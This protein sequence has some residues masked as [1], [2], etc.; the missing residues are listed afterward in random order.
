MLILTDMNKPGKLRG[1]VQGLTLL[2]ACVTGLVSTVLAQQ[3]SPA[4]DSLRSRLQG[5]RGFAKVEL[6]LQLA[7]SYRYQQ[8][9]STTKYA[10]LA[11][12]E[13]AFVS[14]E[15]TFLAL[16]H[17]AFVQLI[18]GKFGRGTTLLQLGQHLPLSE[19]FP[20]K[21]RS[22]YYRLLTIALREQEQLQEAIR[23]GEQ[24]LEYADRSGNL[25][26]RA[27]S[28]AT[29]AELYEMARDTLKNVELLNEALGHYR[30]A[31][32]T[33]GMGRTLNNLGTV[34]RHK[35]TA[36]DRTRALQLFLRSSAL[37]EKINY[38]LGIVINHLNMGLTYAME[39][40]KAD[41]A[42]Y[43]YERAMALAEQINSR[44]WYAKAIV[45][46]G[47]LEGRSG[48]NRKAIALTEEAIEILENNKDFQNLAL[49]YDDLSRYRA[50]TGAY[51]EAYL[52]LKQHDTIEDSLTAADR[53]EE[54][55]KILAKQEQQR[56]NFL[57]QQ[58]QEKLA[59]AAAAR[60]NRQYLFIFTGLA[61]L[62]VFVVFAGKL[63]LPATLRNGLTFFAL[64]MF[65]E[66]V[67]LLL[68]PW[69][70]QYTGGIPFPT[71]A[72]N[73]VFALVF[74]VAQQQLERRLVKKGKP[75]PPT[76]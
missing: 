46:L 45:S 9:D 5:S 62:F 28:T 43:Y 26:E 19:E 14:P 25:V 71:L 54:V 55:G 18:Q 60:A 56:Q 17:L 4:Q 76:A 44:S 66:L 70:T 1:Y 58:Q 41:S 49:H 59:A 50:A 29:L 34:Y 72:L 12:R 8:F 22:S 57:Q 68:D 16:H 11:L 67:M 10:R 32:D 47:I 35:N 7:D 23:Y 42:R 15:H 74:T 3:S 13:N 69:L 75:P 65:F 20:M 48:N 31:N 30:A 64:L 2:L 21:W 52:A 6:A 53:R 33:L 61:V 36:A 38:P 24:S 40:D 37:F 73:G 63:R 39:P 51:R 27:K